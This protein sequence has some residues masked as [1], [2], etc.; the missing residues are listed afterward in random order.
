MQKDNLLTNT[1]QSFNLK[2][3]KESRLLYPTL[4]KVWLPHLVLI[5]SSVVLNH[6]N[7][8]RRQKTSHTFETRVF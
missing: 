4:I 7:D 3:Q 5:N 2:D 1:M 6:L 8:R